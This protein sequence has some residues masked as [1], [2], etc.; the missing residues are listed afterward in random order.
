MHHS[1]DE[2]REFHARRHKTLL[3]LLSKHVSKKL[4]RCLDIGGGGDIADAASEI[5]EEFAAEVHGIDLDSDVERGRDKGVLS[6]RCNVDTEAL[7]YEDE[8]FELVL[9]ASVI[10]HLYNP[11]HVVE[12]IARVLRPGGLLLVEAPNAVSLGRRL[13]A[14]VGKNPFHVFN[15]YNALRDKSIIVDCAVFYTVDEVEALLAHDFAC[16]ERCYGMHSPR[17]NPIKTLLRETAYR[18]NP[19]LADCFFVVAQRRNEA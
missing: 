9:F 16:L 14:F 10:E 1:R 12:E 15:Q 13:D 17:V 6:R 4:E 8:F 18:L 19:R 2:Y 3:S 5:K 11:R 7:P